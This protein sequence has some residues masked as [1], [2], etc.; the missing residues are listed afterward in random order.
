MGIKVREQGFKETDLWRKKVAA[1]V[2][3]KAGRGKIEEVLRESEEFSSIL[4]NY[5]PHPIIVINPDSSV[6][7]VN[8]ALEEL[9][10]F[11]SSEL[12]GVKVPYP[13]WT[14]ETLEKTGKDFSQAMRKGAR[15]LEELFQ[16]KNGERFWVEVTSTPV[17][18]NGVLKYYLANWVDITEHKQAEGILQ[19][20]KAYVES[21]ANGVPDMLA[22][23]NPKEEISYANGAFAQFAGAELKDIVGK[24]MAQ[25]SEEFKLL[26]PEM[27]LIVMKQVK[28]YLQTGTPIIDTE[29]ELTNSRGESVPCLYSASRITDANGRI[30]GE[31]LLIKDISERKRAEEELKQSEQTLMSTL[32]SAP[33]GV[34]LMDL[35]GTFLYGNQRA[36]EIIGYH[37]NEL[38]GRSF[39]HVGLLP[40]EQLIKAA[41]LLECANKGQP[42]VAEGLQLIRKDG[43]LVWTEIN[44]SVIQ[45]GEETVVI[46]FVRDISERKRAEEAL[47]ESEERYRVLF[48]NSIEGVFTTDIA[49]NLTSVNKATAEICGYSTKEL[50]GMSYKKPATPEGAEFLYKAYSKLFRTGE[51]V[52]SLIYEIIRK[53]G[54][55]RLLEGY[56]NAIKKE[57]RIVGFQGTIRDI[58]E[59]KEAEERLKRSFIDLAETVSRAMGSRDPYTASHQ[60]R[61]AGLAQLVGEKI[62]LDQNRLHGIYIG[63]LLHDC[64]KVSIP[65]SILTKSGELA[66]EEWALIH[67]HTKQGYKILKDTNLPWPVADMAL[68][69]HERLD[70]SGY[71]DGI[72]GEE[73]SLEIRILA[74]CDVVEAMSSYR[75]Y[76]PA[77]SK[78]EVVEEI[79]GGRGMKY[80]AGV[81]D[82]MLQIIEN[83]EFDFGWSQKA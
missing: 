21:I 64:G 58:T 37:R 52:R 74:V 3:E 59:Q 63:G 15:G 36:E 82:I 19:Q 61:V 17:M 71:P 75:P 68:H 69:H 30:I 29:A 80:D 25:V 47:Q 43:T 9:T 38:L 33:D 45:R 39:L 11:S 72:S 70:G 53:D 48:E 41:E 8:P 28:K 10:G 49:G 54:K 50:I 32:E 1:L 5:A 67:A 18:V 22:V 57:D 81:V 35:K 26:T 79:E 73:L 16:K 42:I 23:I 13:W 83:G 60:Q 24:P 77:R 7:Y 65:A 12:I 40:E 66:E 14:Q 6:R 55:R 78:E 51:P 31:L 2:R 27:T 44:T 62:G 46:G 56:A 4:L 34:Y 76:R 20:G